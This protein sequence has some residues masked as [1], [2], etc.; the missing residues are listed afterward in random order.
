MSDAGLFQGDVTDLLGDG[1]GAVERR[2]IGQ[3]HH[4]DEIGL[5]LL[6]D[7]AAGD[8][9][10]HQEGEGGEAGVEA[11]HQDL[12]GDR[13]AQRLAIGVRAAAEEAIKALE[14]AAE[15]GIHG[16]GQAVLGCLVVFEQQRGQGGRQGQRINRRDHRRDGDGQ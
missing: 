15:E 14:H 9:L 5:V 11:E 12:A 4:A 8:D 6:R 2:T 7:K 13:A 16:L 1:F 10:E 3:L